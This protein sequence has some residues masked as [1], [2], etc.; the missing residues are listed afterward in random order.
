MTVF[1][2]VTPVGMAYVPYQ[3]WGDVYHSEKGFQQGTMFPVLDMPFRPE[4]GSCQ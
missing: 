4:E 2:D 3:L 1:P